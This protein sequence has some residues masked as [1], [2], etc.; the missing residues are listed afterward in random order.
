MLLKEK[1]VQHPTMMLIP[2][3]TIPLPFPS[4]TIQTRN[5]DMDDEL[6][7]G[8]NKYPFLDI[9]KYT[10]FLKK[11]YTPK[12]KLKGD[13]KIGRYA[14]VHLFVNAMLDL[15]TPINVMPAL[16]YKLLK[17]IDLE[18]TCVI[19]QLSNRSI[20]HPLSILEYVLVQVNNL[21][22]PVDFYMLDMEDESSSKGS[23]LILGRLFSMTA[24][25]MVDVHV[26]M[27]SMEFE[28]NMMHLNIFKAMKHPANNHSVFYL[29]VIDLLVNNY[30][31][32]HS[33]YPD[34][35]DFTDFG[36]TC[37]GSNKCSIC[38]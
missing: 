24:K 16:V 10:K 38:A 19:I 11:L 12:R 3:K 7:K 20:I 29:D 31:H 37:D 28:D 23:K 13:L 15:G 35:V 30:M 26:G 25:T 32:L 1:K 8:G 21:I 27:L 14:S 33:K 34:F 9:P 4:R 36:C 6:L 22:F 5:F 18:P 17:L 2:T